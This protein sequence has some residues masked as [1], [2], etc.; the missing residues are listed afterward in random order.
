MPTS[1][2]AKQ[3]IEHIDSNRV[4]LLASTGLLPQDLCKLDDAGLLQLQEQLLMG[5]VW[6]RWEFPVEWAL[7]SWRLPGRRS[8]R[9]ELAL[10]KGV[11]QQSAYAQRIW[12]ELLRFTLALRLWPGPWAVMAKPGTIRTSIGVVGQIVK[13]LEESNEAAFWSRINR[14]L[15]REYGGKAG[16]TQANTLLYYHKMGALPDGPTPTRRSGIQPRRDRIGEP[17]HSSAANNSRQWMPFPDSYTSAAGWRALHMLREAGPTL[18][19]ALERVQSITPRTVGRGGKPLKKHGIRAANKAQRDELMTHWDWRSPDGE[20]LRSL[21]FT[22]SMVA[23]VKGP[24]RSVS[25]P[26]VTYAQGIELLYLLQA[27]HLWVIALSLAGR[28]GEIVEMKMDCIRRES[29]CTPTGS[30]VTW[31]LEGISGRLAEVPLPSE[32]VFAL[33]QQMRLAKLLKR[34][35]G[36]DNDRLWIKSAK[37]NGNPGGQLH[38]FESMLLKFNSAFELDGLMENTS[39]HMHRFRKTFVRIVALALVHAPKILMDILGHRDEQMTVMRYVLSDP[40]ILTEIEEFTRELIVLK[41]LAAVSER[42]TLQGKAAPVFRGRVEQYAKL[43]GRSAFEPA[44]LREFVEAITEGGTGWAVI[45]PGKVCTGFRNGG[46]CNDASGQANPHYCTPGCHNQLLFPEYEKVDGTVASTIVEAIESMDYMIE[47]LR[48]SS[49]EGEE[50]LVAQYVGQITGLLNQ[51]H[52]VDR[53]FRDRHLR[54]PE[55]NAKFPKVVLLP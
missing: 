32:V 1:L 13:G 9:L 21:P 5:N 17:E 43:L 44:N 23:S 12:R 11:D 7:G 47:Q 10:P 2:L 29:T 35:Y 24:R 20:P 54:D 28:H 3:T 55:V 19:G 6:G 53:H 34:I 51:W 26:P 8:Y 39:L 42:E 30:F 48:H 40:G 37:G 4:S 16:P 18:I 22:I 31:K 33:Q 41:G 15:A 36:V 14:S 50:M 45:G 27:C 25:W 52:Q 38:V 49:C 46:L